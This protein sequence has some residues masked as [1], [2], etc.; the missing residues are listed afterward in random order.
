M[1]VITKDFKD[2]KVAVIGLG[3]E[4]SSV[5]RFLQDKDAQITIFD[6]KKES[7]LDFKGIDK[8]KIK[9]VCG[10]KYLSRG[11]KEFDII[12]R[13]QGVK[14]NLLQILEAEEVGVEISSEIKLF[15]DL[16]PSKIIGVTGTKGKGTT[17]TLISNILES[18]G[19]DV[20]LAG[21]IGIPRLDLLPRL[22]ST[23]WVVLE[24]SSTQLIDLHKSPHIAVV[25]NITTDHL[26]WHRDR[27]E[28]VN[29]K[30][31]IVK[32]QKDNDFAVLAYD[33]KDSRKFS[34]LT[35]GE[36]FYFSNSKKVNGAYVNNGRILLEIRNKK[37]EIG[38]VENLLLRGRHNWENVCAAV[39][40]SY[41]AGASINSIKQTVFSFKGLEHRLEL[42]GEV[43]GVKFYNDSFSTNPQTTIAAIKSFS[44]P[45]T[46]IL[47]GSDK[48][49]NYDEMA[50]EITKS[51][52]LNSIIIG[53]IS[54][55]IKRSLQKSGYKQNITELG[56]PKTKKIIEEAV[57]VTPKGGIVL[58][59]PAAASFDMF[60][61]YKD[62]GNQFK[63]AV[64]VL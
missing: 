51:T 53:D 8:S 22:K 14:R 40:A 10:E 32:Y 58:L 36:V 37:I 46:L 16:S 3:I 42:V 61:D 54:K 60:K 43:G 25:L 45:I 41:L 29:S 17:S 4:G 20:Y 30:T 52:V 13:S 15:F 63:E 6:R 24:L 11:F 50:R 64:K 38:R 44:E 33:Y 31:Q 34:K 1:I 27:D 18:A 12:F 56:Y 7:E 39:C 2:K 47:G 62:R 55:K 49:L 9:T 48:G 21:N 35:R 59:S 23:N 5:V 26:D 28:Y 19:Y 57:K